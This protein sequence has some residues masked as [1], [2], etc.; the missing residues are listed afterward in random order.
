VLAIAGY[1]LRQPSEKVAGGGTAISQPASTTSSKHV[2]SP[3]AATPTSSAA[4]ASGK[5]PLV[6]L[7]NTI[8][9]GLAQ[10][11]RATFVAGGWQVTSVGNLRDD[12]L[13]TCA[14]YD[15]GVAGAQAAAEALMQQFPAIKRTVAKFAGLP[16]GPIVV[17]LTP[18]YSSG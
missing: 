9:T 1:A 18:D 6:I 16:A 13:S 12:I 14:Y 8:V 17:V 5:L 7:N 3:P 4:G 15:P 11:A 2:S 10:Q